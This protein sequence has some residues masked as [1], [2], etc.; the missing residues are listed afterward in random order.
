MQSRKLQSSRGL[1]AKGKEEEEDT[2]MRRQKDF[3]QVRLIGMVHAMEI[4]K[5]YGIEGLEKD[6]QAR[7]RTN[8]NPPM[9]FF[10]LDQCT[11]E[12][13]CWSIKRV[14]ILAMAALHD[15]FGFG[16]SRMVKFLNKMAEASALIQSGEATWWDYSQEID[17]QLGLNIVGTENGIRV[18][19]RTKKK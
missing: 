13:K 14:S 10:D 9:Y 15:E 8:V 11:D 16:P 6:I 7:K 3:D 17:S 4:V 1:E 2:E 5:K 19:M 12:I 18:E